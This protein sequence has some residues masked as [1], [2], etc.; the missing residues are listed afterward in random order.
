MTALRV[1]QL[2][3][4]PVARLVHSVAAHNAEVAELDTRIE[5][6]FR[7]HQDA[8]V[9]LTMPGMEPTLGAEF[10]AV[11]GGDLTAFA[12]PDRLA[13]FAGLAPV[14]WDS[15]SGGGE[16]ELPEQGFLLRRVR[17]PGRAGHGVPGGQH[18]RAALVHVNM[19][20]MQEV[21]ADPKQGDKLTDADCGRCR[22]CSGPM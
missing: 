17:R 15:G 8:E 19:L 7:Q 13:G 2:G 12:N 6:R 4:E 5:S 10:G 18:A 11:T 21:L 16:L 22:R 9:I 1:E 3:A 14:P 20:L